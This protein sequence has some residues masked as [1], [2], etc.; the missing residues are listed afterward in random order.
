MQGGERSNNGVPGSGGGA[1]RDS[2]GSSSPPRP[3]ATQIASLPL[4]RVEDFHVGK[5]LALG[6]DAAPPAARGEEEASY[7]PVALAKAHLAKVVADMHAMKDE[8]ALKVARI[9]ERY[10]AIE[11]DTQTHYEKLM[12][13]LKSKA[14]RKIQDEKRKFD[15]LESAGAE[16]DAQARREKQ[17]LI[18]QHDEA[19]RVHAQQREQWQ[20]RLESCLQA[21]EDAMAKC[22][23]LVASELQRE[24]QSHRDDKQRTLDALRNELLM[25]W[26]DAKSE[27]ARAVAQLE[28]L[29]RE[30]LVKEK[31]FVRRVQQMQSAFEAEFETHACLHAVVN[32]VVDMAQ[33]QTLRSKTK[34]LS[35]QISALELEMRASA[36]RETS[37]Q[38]QLARARERFAAVERAAVADAMKCMLQT[39][40]LTPVARSPLTSTAQTMTTTPLTATSDSQTDPAEEQVREADAT[41]ALAL[42]RLEYESRVERSRE[43]NADV[44][45]SKIHLRA[46]KDELQVLLSKKNAAKATIKTWLAEFQREHQR[47]PTIE[48]KAQVKDLYLL[49][50]AAEDTFNSK[51]EHVAQLKTQ[52]HAVVAKVEAVA[53]WQA[54]GDA[55]IKSTARPTEFDEDVSIGDS[56][57]ASSSSSVSSQ[58]A[59]SSA[60]VSALEREV[61]LLRQE[62]AGARKVREDEEPDHGVDPRHQQALDLETTI[63]GLAAEIAARK[64]EKAALET[65]IEQLRLHLEFMELHHDGELLDEHVDD[66]SDAKQQQTTTRRASPSTFFDDEEDAESSGDEDGS[67]REALE[68]ELLLD[69]ADDDG[70]VTDGQ[71]QAD[72]GEDEL[73]SAADAAAAAAQAEDEDAESPSEKEDFMSCL[74]LVSLVRDAVE[75]GKAQ[76]NRGDKAKCC[77][78]YLKASEACVDELKRMHQSRREDIAGFKSAATEASRLPPARG[79]VVLRKQ[80]DALL[81]DCEQRL[82]AREERAAARRKQQLERSIA[83]TAAAKTPS[84]KRKAEPKAPPSQAASPSKKARA[85]HKKGT[86]PD[87]DSALERDAAAASPAKAAGANSKVIDE[88]KQKLK[89]L[90]TKAKGDKVRITQLENALAKAEAQ[91]SSGGGSSG[92]GNGSGANAAALERKVADMEKKHRHALE[93]AEKSSRKEIAGLA[94]QLQAAQTKSAAL[95][96]QVALAQKELSTLG[97]KATQLSKLEDEMVTLKAQAAHAAVVAEELASAKTQLGKLETSYKEE[98]ALRKKYYNQIEDMKGKIRVYARCRPMSGSELERGCLPCVTFTDEY[99]LELETPRGPKPFAYDQVFSPASSQDAV[100]E[101]TKNLMQS[102]VDGYNVCIFAYGQTGSGKTFTMTGSES[103]PGLT[104]RAITHLFALADEAKSN[105]TITFQA[106]MLELYNDTLIDLFHLVDSGHDRDSGSAGG[107]GKLE[108]KKNEKGMVF[109]QNAVVKACTSPQQTLKLF[110]SA[111]KKRQVGSTKMNAESSRSHS[112]FSILVESYNK[113]TKATTVGKLSLVDLAGSERAGKTGA[114]AERLKEAQAINKSLSGANV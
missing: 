97:G 49:F 19:N 41:A 11:Q 62:L 24:A 58:P 114:T 72:D 84:P 33:Q 30:V 57:P 56:R 14:K 7:I 78:T 86:P 101:D 105:H 6:A 108:I 73:E 5:V 83:A 1:S 87:V 51:K 38:Q 95:Q 25:S 12:G 47:E 66:R 65:Q 10:K 18:D 90:E 96:E 20:Q 27:S 94:Q 93:D 42:P 79:S 61:E 17:E 75:Q 63:A 67:A 102:A 113:T 85:S 13:E 106:S 103:M 60:K 107:S 43:L 98:Q 74:H 39:L 31:A 55:T 76:F 91:L 36:Q 21:H 50:K 16:R 28:R 37:L 89:A 15:A 81:A 92:A 111:N 52:H 2:S 45:R 99:S 112:V 59:P 80:L 9:M 104:P 109:V 71:D 64:S 48:D 29:R 46:Q 4:A 22:H 82:K 40:E 100:F 44:L 77:Q 88:Y 68:E 35:T 54:L 32:R 23:A 69:A 110:E 70:E 53:Q 3:L 26:E 34:A 8:Q